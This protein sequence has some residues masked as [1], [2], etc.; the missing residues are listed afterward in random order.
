MS[1][2][3]CLPSPTANNKR[4]TASSLFPSPRLF[5]GLSPKGPSDCEAAMSPTSILETKPFIGNPFFTDRNQRRSIRDAIAPTTANQSRHHPWDNGDSKAIGLGLVDAL[6]NE[7]IDKQASKPESR[8]VLFGSQ[9]KIQIPPIQSS[10]ISPSGSIES[11]RSPI[12]FGIKT[13][14]SQLALYSP[15]RR[16]PVGSTNMEAVVPTSSPRLFTGCLTPSEMELSE[17]YT[18]VISHGPNPRTTH[19]F[20]NCIVESC[21][22]GFVALRKE[23]RSLA[24]NSG[25]T[26]DDFLSFCYACRKNL[27]QGKDIFMYRGEKAFCSR[28]C[29]YQEMLFDEE[30]EKCSGDLSDS[31]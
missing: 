29:R 31:L 17:D 9:L 26:S 21:G 12:E 24:D 23:N 5:S 11:P 16:S 4:P 25:Y 14:N 7:K 28:E 10:S 22:D 18:C 6:N 27:G 30:M 8:M 20:D 3:T 19:I 13:K 1:D 2:Y 15:A